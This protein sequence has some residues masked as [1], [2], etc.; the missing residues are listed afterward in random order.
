MPG[1]LFISAVT[2]SEWVKGKQVEE[3]VAIKNT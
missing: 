3:V 1:S 2:A